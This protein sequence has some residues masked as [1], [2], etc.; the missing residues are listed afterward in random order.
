MARQTIEIPVGPGL[1]AFL[2]EQ[3]PARLQAWQALELALDPNDDEDPFAILPVATAW[4][5]LHWAAAHGASL[6]H[7]A[8]WLAQN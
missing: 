5:L 2:A 7:L 6:P 3:T 4:A 1:R 8:A